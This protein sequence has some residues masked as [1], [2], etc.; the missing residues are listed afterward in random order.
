[1]VSWK[2]TPLPRCGLEL[3]ETG[4]GAHDLIQRDPPR[5]RSSPLSHHGRLGI[6]ELLS[7]RHLPF[8]PYSRTS[9]GLSV[10]RCPVKSH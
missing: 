7:V 4:R 3:N 5:D 1:M 2:K 10:A 9:A 8:R 6:V